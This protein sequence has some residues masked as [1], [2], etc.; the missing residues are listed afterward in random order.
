M[1]KNIIFDIGFVL[2]DF[3][4]NQYIAKYFS[5]EEKEYICSHIWGASFWHELDMG[6]RPCQDILNDYFESNGEYSSIM[7]KA[8]ENFGECMSL[9][10]FVIPWFSEL[11]S[12]G[13]NIYY[14]SN[15]SDF[16]YNANPPVMNFIQH[17][18]GGVFSHKVHLTKPDIAIYKY[19]CDKYNL[20]PEECIFID[21]LDTNITAAIDYGINGIV[22]E[23]YENTYKKV[24]ELL[25]LS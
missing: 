24:E 13:L 21:D 1:I 18:D 4:F 10:D 9:R 6:K 17:M 7:K 15:W 16:L 14:L 20:I 23:G 5:K 3:D 8:M 22:Y 19:I 25:I 12:K 2:V 11:K